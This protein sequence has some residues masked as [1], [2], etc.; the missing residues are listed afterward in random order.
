MTPNEQVKQPTE[1]APADFSE[2]IEL[3]PEE[4]KEL[5]HMWKNSH[6]QI[7]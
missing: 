1:D 5:L 7:N 3:T 4:K 6:Q 2:I